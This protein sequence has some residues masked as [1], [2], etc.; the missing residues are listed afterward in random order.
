MATKEQMLQ[1]VAITHPR[2]EGICALPRTKATQ[3]QHIISEF[4]YNS[5]DM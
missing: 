3:F 4:L 1:L 2:G 5:E